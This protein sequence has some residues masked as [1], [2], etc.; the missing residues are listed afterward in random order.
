MNQ[1]ML[2]SIFDPN[3][4]SFRELSAIKV[5]K[6][7]SNDKL[8]RPIICRDEECCKFVGQVRVVIEFFPI[9]TSFFM[10]I[11]NKSLIARV[12]NFNSF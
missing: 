5:L 10:S 4:N 1:A 11:F 6:V 9:T 8:L 2:I 3:Q 7:S 12:W